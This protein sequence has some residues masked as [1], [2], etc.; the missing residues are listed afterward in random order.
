MK[1]LNEYKD[2]TENRDHL[3]NGNTEKSPNTD[4]NV[5]LLRLAGI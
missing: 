5:G 4:K 1:R 3:S 2:Q